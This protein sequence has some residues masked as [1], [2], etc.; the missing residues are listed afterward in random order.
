MNILT[1]PI[2]QM[3]RGSFSVS[4]TALSAFIAI[5]PCH[6]AA[7]LDVDGMRSAEMPSP[8]ND[9]HKPVANCAVGDRSSC[10]V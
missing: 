5:E 2:A 1:K 6:S 4:V 7:A 8:D 9:H 10:R 3:P